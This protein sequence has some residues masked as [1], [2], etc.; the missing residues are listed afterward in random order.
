MKQPGFG[1]GLRVSS[2]PPHSMSSGASPVRAPGMWGLLPSAVFSHPS[3]WGNLVDRPR[4]CQAVGVSG[5]LS[6]P[7]VSPLPFYPPPSEAVP[8]H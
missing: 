4:S 2:R 3:L 5:T 1:A 8:V 7:H 6:L